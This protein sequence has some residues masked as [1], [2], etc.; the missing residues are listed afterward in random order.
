MSV[1]EEDWPW[2]LLVFCN[3][4]PQLGRPGGQGIGQRFC[5]SR[6][7][8]LAQKPFCVPITEGVLPPAQECQ[9]CPSVGAEVPGALQ[10]DG[11]QQEQRKQQPTTAR[12]SAVS[13]A[14]GRPRLAHRHRT[15]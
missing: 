14:G 7:S 10:P 5:P 1:Q 15:L 13:Q 3:W 11:P 2:W 8:D 9:P 12:S 6:L 4:F